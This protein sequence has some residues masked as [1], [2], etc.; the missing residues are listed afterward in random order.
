VDAKTGSAQDAQR[1][2]WPLIGSLVLT[3]IVVALVCVPP[4]AGLRSVG[5]LLWLACVYMLVAACVHALAVWSVYRIQKEGVREWALVWPVVWG[6]WIAVVWLPL[7]A[8]LTYEHSSWVAGIVPLAAVFLTLFVVSRRR[9]EEDESSAWATVTGRELFA[10]DESPRLWRALVPSLL[11]VL[12]MDGGVALLAA[13]HAWMAGVLF[14][15]AAAYVAERLLSRTAARVKVRE[16]SVRRASAGTSMTVWMLTVVALLPFLLGVGVAVRGWMGMPAVHASV[17]VANFMHRAERGYQGIILTRPKMRHEIVTPLLTANPEGF[18]KEEKT[19]PFDGQYWYFQAPNTRPGVDA[20]VVRAD[21]AK[22]SIASTNSLPIV[23]EAHQRLAREMDM[24][25]CRAVR[26]NVLNADAVPGSITLELQFRDNHGYI[27]SM[28][29]KVLPSS[30]VSPM[31]LHRAP[32]QETLVFQVPRAAKGK[33]IDEITVK[34]Q[35][36]RSRSLA[37]P[38]VAIE[39][40]AFER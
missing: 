21:P 30:V 4:F 8:L 20:H 24:S 29:R 39:S 14:A 10:V 9:D 25:C 13:S 26:L 2:T 37:A 31:P 15:A 36:E 1:F 23:M 27:V 33:Q 19:I 11:I 22:S 38:E 16:S 35:P 40:F 18:R 3:G 17:H 32:V 5:H 7:V 6:A 28:G 34:V 12:A